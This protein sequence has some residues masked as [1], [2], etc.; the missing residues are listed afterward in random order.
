M[1]NQWLCMRLRNAAVNGKF[2]AEPITESISQCGQ[3]VVF[4]SSIHSTISA[5]EK[6][7]MQ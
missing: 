3:R 7:E 1:Q 4:P 2:E 6:I 5:G